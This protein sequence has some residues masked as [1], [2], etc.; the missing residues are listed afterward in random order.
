MTAWPH[1]FTEPVPGD[2]VLH[3]LPP[4]RLSDQLTITRYL[5]VRQDDAGDWRARLLFLESDGRTRETADIFTGATEAE[6]WQSVR[7]L[8]E[9]HMRALY[10]SLV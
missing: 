7:R 5:R 8:H 6:L 3:E 4:L 1:R 2:P 9:H 10:L